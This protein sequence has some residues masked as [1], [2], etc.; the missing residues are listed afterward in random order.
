MLRRGEKI[1]DNGIIMSG[2]FD[3]DGILTSGTA[4]DPK[5]N[6]YKSGKFSE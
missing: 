5:R 2:V 1:C 6:I 4:Y 3:G